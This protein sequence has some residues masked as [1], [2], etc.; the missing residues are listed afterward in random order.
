MV[1]SNLFMDF[2]H[3][4]R[5]LFTISILTFFHYSVL[6]STTLIHAHTFAHGVA[7]YSY[8]ADTVSS[9]LNATCYSALWA[10]IQSCSSL[11]EPNMFSKTLNLTT[12]G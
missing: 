7:F 3:F 1:F 4:S 6:S 11:T 12:N 9:A 8:L 5:S 2:T 10:T